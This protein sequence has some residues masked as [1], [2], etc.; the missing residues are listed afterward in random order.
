[1]VNVSPTAVLECLLAL[2]LYAVSYLV[3][4][5]LSAHSTMNFDAVSFSE[6]QMVM[7]T[8]TTPTPPKLQSK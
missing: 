5:R 6:C 7:V 1:M 3:S 2:P 8:K 4:S